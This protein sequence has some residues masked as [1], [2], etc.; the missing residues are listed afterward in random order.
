[1]SI[2]FDKIGKLGF[3]YMRLPRING[4]FDEVQINKMA[5]MFLES[6][7]T[8]FD[9]AYVYDGAEG[10]LRKSVIERYPREKF[11]VASKLPLGMVN[12]ERTMEDLFN[13][14]LERLGTDYIDFYLL[15]GINSSDHGERLGAWDFV[16]DLKA[17]GKIRHIGF[18]F[19]GHPDGLKDIFTKHPEVEFAQLQINYFDWT[20]PKINAKRLH[21]IACEFNVPIIIMEPLLGGKLA[22]S[23]SPIADMFK[24]LDPNVSLASW[25]LRYVAE[26]KGVFVTLS[27]MSNLEQLEDNI[28]TYADLKP[29][30]ENEHKV[31]DEAVK[32]L[33]SL[34][35][36]ECTECNYCKDCPQKIRI[37][38]L[39][40]LYNDFLVHKTSTNLSGSYNWM[41]SGFGKAKDCTACGVCEDIC[42]QDLE[43]IDTMK[44]ISKLFD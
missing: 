13:T 28:K 17:K 24:E 11:Q 12:D 6:G 39:I 8:Y 38:L 41:T 37:P 4:E 44:K 43:I 29:L 20:R 36:I 26:L 16:A 9:V 7:G 18:S 31:I 33:N 27:G 35:R 42:P 3:G 25:A 10:A 14:S 32:L 40:N 1:M 21:E 5:D 2:D 15:H 19:H 30:S 22:S 34:P 23:D